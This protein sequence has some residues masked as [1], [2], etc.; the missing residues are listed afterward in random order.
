[1]GALEQEAQ[2]EQTTEQVSQEAQEQSNQT[3]EKSKPAGYNPVD[4]SSIQDEGLRKQLEDRFG[5]YHH[6][7]KDYQRDLKKQGRELNHFKTLAT[8]EIERLAGTVNQVTSQV[9][10]QA[11]TD[12][13][14]Q[15]KEQMKAAHESGDTQGYIDAQ[16]RLL[17]LKAKKLVQSQT[18]Q[19]L[20]QKTTTQPTQEAEPEVNLSGD[21]VSVISAWMNET[22][23][24]GNPVRAWKDENSNDFEQAELETKAVFL[25]AKYQ[26]LTLAQKLME[27]DRRMGLNTKQNNTSQAVLGGSLNQPNKNA[28][29][30]LSP[31]QQQLAVK[32]RFGGPSAKSDAEHIEAYRKSIENLQKNSN[33]RRRP[34]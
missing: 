7:V 14:A 26:H 33:Q 29:I 17:E 25:G 27:I 30:T 12:A 31:R 2:V 15:V 34:Q 4:L 1:M 16:D 9:Q 18:Q 13:E 28:R 11:I 21:E 8:Q 3:T 6:Q 32:T 23:N 19:R 5:Y 24:S 10:H 20:Q 22:D